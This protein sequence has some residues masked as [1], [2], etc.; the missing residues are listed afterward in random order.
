MLTSPLSQGLNDAK[1][2]LC[3]NS[4][5]PGLGWII[6][7]VISYPWNKSM[8]HIPAKI[9]L[10]LILLTFPTSNRSWHNLPQP[11]FGILARTGITP[12]TSC[13]CPRAHWRPHLEPPCLGL[14][15]SCPCPEANLSH[16]HGT[17]PRSNLTVA[18]GGHAP[19]SNLATC[20]H[21]SLPEGFIRKHIKIWV[22]TSG[23]V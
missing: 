21:A 22:T 4:V 8:A 5:Q 2:A 19:L 13:C 9:C 1:L 23:Q 11:D 10:L 15:W 20:C 6:S 17:R 14:L 16:V 3:Q 18:G 12:P 7:P